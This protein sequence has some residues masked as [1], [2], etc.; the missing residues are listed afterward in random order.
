VRLRLDNSYP[1]SAASIA[2]L[3]PAPGAGILS[4]S[5]GLLALTGL[6][7]L[8]YVNLSLAA[9]PYLALDAAG[10][11]ESSDSYSG[12]YILQTDA[13]ISTV[14]ASGLVNLIYPEE[15]GG[16]RPGDRGALDGRRRTHPPR[17]L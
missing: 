2:S 11:C 17:P 12:V 4:A 14:L 8:S 1:V 10:W 9:A 16:L 6:E 7:S 5:E 15:H 13:A 3:A